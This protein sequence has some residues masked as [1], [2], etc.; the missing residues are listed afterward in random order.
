MTLSLFY[1]EVVT[2][3]G[4]PSFLFRIIAAI[5]DATLIVLPFTFLKRY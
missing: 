3:E 5:A 2:Y 1:L 4:T